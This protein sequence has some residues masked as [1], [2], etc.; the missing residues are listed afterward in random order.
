MG[1]QRDRTVVL[2]PPRKISPSDHVLENERNDGPRYVVSCSRWW[3]EARSAEYKWD[4]AY[5]GFR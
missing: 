3:T 2:R 5:T 4:T 1:K